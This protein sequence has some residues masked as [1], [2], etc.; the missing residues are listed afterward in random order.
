MNKIRNAQQLSEYEKTQI[1][2][3]KSKAEFLQGCG[4]C[5][6]IPVI[7]VILFYKS[8]RFS[9]YGLTKSFNS[10]LGIFIKYV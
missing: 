2:L 8:N 1:E 10:N 5:L 4:G 7:L 9:F 3:A 6:M